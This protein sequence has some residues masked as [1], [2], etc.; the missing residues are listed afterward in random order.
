MA[1][2]KPSSGIDDATLAQRTQAT[3]QLGDEVSRLLDLEK[4]VIIAANEK[5]KIR[6]WAW[7]AEETIEDWI[8]AQTYK[9]TS[10]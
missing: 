7:R 6:V 2:R 1:A 4:L 3:H 9:E 10:K 8:E 5:H